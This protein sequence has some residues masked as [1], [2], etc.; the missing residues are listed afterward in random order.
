MTIYM[1]TK[2]QQE[3]QK[4][5]NLS[6]AFREANRY[7]AALADSSSAA[8]AGWEKYADSLEEKIKDLTKRYQ[9]ILDLHST[10]ENLYYDEDDHE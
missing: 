2:L 3:K 8:Y 10:A 7:M 9:K 4:R 5:I 1:G 6:I